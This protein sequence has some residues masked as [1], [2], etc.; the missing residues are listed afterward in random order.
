MK[1]HPRICKYFNTHNTCKFGDD[2]AYKHKVT[3]ESVD[4]NKLEAK[5]DTLEK[6]VKA[7]AE[8]IEVL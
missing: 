3:N 2:C 6:T 8:Q 5:L 1:R 7:M 4:I